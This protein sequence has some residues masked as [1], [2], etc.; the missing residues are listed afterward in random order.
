MSEYFDEET[1]ITVAVLDPDNIYL[2]SAKQTYSAGTKP[3]ENTVIKIP[4]IALEPN[5]ALQWNGS[6]YIVIPDYRGQTFYNKENG[7]PVEIKHVGALPENLTD[8][9]QPSQLYEWDNKAK[10]W[11]LNQSKKDAADIAEIESKKSSLLAHA[12]DQ[13]D[14]L[15]DELDLD[16]AEDIN[17]TKARLKAWKIYRV[18]LN[19]VDTANPVW[20]EVPEK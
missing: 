20:P 8:Q 5:Q 6:D 10:K 19:K 7:A 17:V 16:L 1:T 11:I 18:K 4:D 14:I 13:I 2:G 15:Q 3:G 9:P 12:K